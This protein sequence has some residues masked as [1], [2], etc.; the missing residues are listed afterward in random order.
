MNEREF[1]RYIDNFCQAVEDYDCLK[2]ARTVIEIAE[3]VLPVYYGWAHNPSEAPRQTI[4]R[5]KD[6]VEGQ[7]VDLEEVRDKIQKEEYAARHYA[8]QHLTTIAS[9]WDYTIQNYARDLN[10]RQPMHLNEH[11][12]ENAFIAVYVIRQCL[13]AVINPSNYRMLGVGLHECLLWAGVIVTIDRV[14]EII[15]RSFPERIN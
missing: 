1:R 9:C 15:S 8:Y 13:N 10:S 4:N 5:L 14:K 2:I 12:R 11:G 7:S 3:A 6:Y